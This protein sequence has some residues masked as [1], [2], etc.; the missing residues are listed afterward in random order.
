MFKRA[1]ARNEAF[2]I[3][4]RRAVEGVDAVQVNPGG[5]DP[6]HPAEGHADEV[7]PQG[8]VGG[9]DTQQGIGG[10]FARMHL[11]HPA[12]FGVVIFMKPEK[13]LDVGKPRQSFHGRNIGI[14]DFNPGFR[15][16]LTDGA[17]RCHLERLRHADSPARFGRHFCEARCKVLI[18]FKKCGDCNPKFHFAGLDRA[19]K[20]G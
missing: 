10:V 5:I 4:D 1:G 17:D 15:V 8:G 9:K 19:S 16:G 12:P 18:F 11:Q 3:Q 14:I 2:D 20:I 13:D 7:R 6:L